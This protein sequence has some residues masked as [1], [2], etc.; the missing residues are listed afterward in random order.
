MKAGSL[1]DL[2]EILYQ[3]ARLGLNGRSEDVGLYLRRSLEKHGEKWPELAKRMSGLMTSTAARGSSLRRASA[4]P[5]NPVPV[6][7]D[8]RLELLRRED[9]LFLETMPQ[10]RQEVQAALDQVV[11]ERKNQPHLL[12]AGLHPSRTVLL[13]G[14]PGVGKT[15]AARW[16]AWRLDLPLFTLDL[17]AV[18]SSL[19][20]RTG[21]NLRYVLDYAKTLPCVLLLDE[22]DAIAKRRD[23]DSEIGELKRL[24]TV[25]L[26]E[27]DHWPVC[28][29][30]VAAT[31]HSGLLDPAIWR[32]FE[33][34]IEFPLPN[35]TESK[36]AVSRLLEGRIE[37]SHSLIGILASL[38]EG[39]SYSEIERMILLAR[40]RAVMDKKPIEI[41]LKGMALELLA[42]FAPK[43]RAQFAARLVE[44]GLG[45]E[46]E[47]AAITQVSRNT[48][49]SRI[50]PTRRINTA[51]SKPGRRPISTR[52]EIA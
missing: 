2:F 4:T 8:S 10:L 11:D 16:L 33:A 35:Q 20:G 41:V 19:L 7:G 44:E 37:G 30:L 14:P 23:D 12:S 47:V 17:A 43:Q 34:R 51:A 46:R 28:G 3:L 5:P 52:E 26:Q 29:L 42:D 13:T 24:V 31:N 18:M 50:N 49:R 1:S 22:F 15:L 27:I 40:K 32:R 25:L 45:S 9:V 38:L 39:R 48:I 6:D 36:L 21:N